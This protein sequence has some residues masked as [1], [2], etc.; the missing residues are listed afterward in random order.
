MRSMMACPT[1]VSWGPNRIDVVWSS[2]QDRNGAAAGEEDLGGS[3]SSDP[4][5]VADQ[6]NSIH[7]LYNS[8]G[9]LVDRRWIHGHGWNTPPT[10][11]DDTAT[12]QIDA[13]RPP[14]VASWG[15]NRVD[16]FFARRDGQTYVYRK[17]FRG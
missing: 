16:V 13:A 2:L 8:G 11:L 5:A 4:S 9:Q 10:P 1:A 3:L 7:V 14:A 15:P 6:L 12:N 17:T